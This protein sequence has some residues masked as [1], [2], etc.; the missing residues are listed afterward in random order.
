ERHGVR[1]LAAEPVAADLGA[2][3]LTYRG[4]A[5]ERRL[6]EDQ[7]ELIAAVARDDVG[8]AADGLEDRGCLLE[9][10]IA[11]QVPVLVVVALEGVDVENR[12][13]KGSALAPGRSAPPAVPSAEA[14]AVA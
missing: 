8:A 9:R 2:R 5:V 7:D 12:G 13:L 10:D 3:A 14:P 11:P 6:G 1:R 4:R